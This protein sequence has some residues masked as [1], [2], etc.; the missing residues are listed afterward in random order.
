MALGLSRRTPLVACLCYGAYAAHQALRT[1]RFHH[2]F[3]VYTFSRQVINRVWAPW[4]QKQLQSGVVCAS[5]C[6][7]RSDKVTLHDYIV[8]T[9]NYLGTYFF[10]R[11]RLWNCGSG[12][13]SVNTCQ[14]A[15]LGSTT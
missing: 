4:R 12:R 3:N 6:Q 15:G 8:P 5:F 1:R 7:T 13:N 11:D 9:C 14:N 2:A 10:M